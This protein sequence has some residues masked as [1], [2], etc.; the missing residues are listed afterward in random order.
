VT[1]EVI[2]SFLAASGVRATVVTLLFYVLYLAMLVAGNIWLSLWTADTTANTTT[3][4]RQQTNRR[5]G[6]YGGLV[7]AQSKTRKVGIEHN[8][9]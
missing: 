8:L 3:M 9:F 1:W 5:M 7:L 6:V 2:R 4:P